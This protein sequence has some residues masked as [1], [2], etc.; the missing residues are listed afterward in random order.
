M[1]NPNIVSVTSILG[2]TDVAKLGTTSISVTSNA[3]GS[4]KVLKINTL[5]VSCVGASDADVTVGISRS[6]QTY[7]FAKNI[8][9]PAGSLLALVAKENPV[10]VMEGDSLVAVSGAAN[11][12]EAI[13]SYEEIS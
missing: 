3:G 7:H 1:A 11:S 10:Y 5:I 2:K 13:C 8:L 6:S 12:A 9:V 4:G